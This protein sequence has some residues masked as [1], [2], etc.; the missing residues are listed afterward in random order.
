MVEIGDDNTF[1]AYCSVGTPAEHKTRATEG[2]V[3]IGSRNKINEFTT[4]NA[5]LDKFTLLGNNNFLL[6][7]THIGHDAVVENDCVLSCNVV[8]GG[9]SHIM[10]GVNMGLASV[11]HQFRV[12]GAYAMIGMN[13][14]CTKDIAPFVTA[15]GSPAKAKSINERGMQRNG[16]TDI[17]VQLC[18]NAMKNQTVVGFDTKIIA[19]LE[20]FDACVKR[21]RPDGH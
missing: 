3:L 11:V 14:T 19:I 12:I 20:A 17:E 16:F 5:A 4:I 8:I 15:Y 1:E 6:R 13:A 9:H 18:K 21:V 7:G 2:G 10:T